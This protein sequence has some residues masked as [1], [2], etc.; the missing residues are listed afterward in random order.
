M[1]MKKY[2]ADSLFQVELVES[3]KI[4]KVQL[5]FV[6]PFNLNFK[7]IRK[8]TDEFKGPGIY[9]ISYKNEVIYIGSYSSINPSIIHDRWKKHI[10][11]FTN[12]GYR[13][14]FNSIKSYHLIPETLKL[15]FDQENSLRCCDTGT[16][17]YL[18]RLLFVLENFEE[19]KNSNDNSLI[20]DFSFYYCKMSQNKGSVV[21]IEQE[22][23]KK[24]N[25]RC[26]N[27]YDRNR[28]T[29]ESLNAHLV[30]LELKQ[31]MKIIL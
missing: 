30:E 9:C 12:R 3:G 22:L 7:V 4:N 10:M 1:I 26:N 17:T 31:L 19:F 11:T 15:Y 18:N 6:W 24:L 28:I 27:G 29:S 2:L 20:K 16:V 8:K 21:Q 23:I 25:P 14:G 13:L 5:K